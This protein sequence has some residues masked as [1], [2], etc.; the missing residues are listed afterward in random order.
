MNRTHFAT[1]G[2]AALAIVAMAAP[3]AAQTHVTRT[4]GTGYDVV[5]LYEPVGMMTPAARMV[6]VPQVPDRYG[7]VIVH[8]YGNEPVRISPSPVRA[9]TYGQP[10]RVVEKK[11]Q[12]GLYRSY[13]YCR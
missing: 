9:G 12:K 11:D 1:G 5:P 4:N 2:L 3:A 10:C 13:T 7:A 8:G 6:V